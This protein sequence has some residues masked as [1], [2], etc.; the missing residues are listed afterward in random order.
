MLVGVFNI[1]RLSLEL[2]PGLDF[3]VRWNT[4]PQGNSIFAMVPMDKSNCLRKSLPR[5]LHEVNK[6]FPA[7]KR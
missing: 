7:V 6:K 1:R 2:R 5:K 4:D 3:G